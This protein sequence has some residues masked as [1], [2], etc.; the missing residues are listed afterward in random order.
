MTTALVVTCEH[1]GNN[2]PR[3]YRS[4]FT[5]PLQDAL[6]DHRGYDPGALKLA[7]TIS[8]A[9]SVPLMYTTVT[10]LLVDCNR[11]SGHRAL[12]GPEVRNLPEEELAEIRALHYEP[13]RE[14][15]SETIGDLIRRRKRVLHISVHTFTP[16]LDGTD[17]TADIALLYDPAREEEKKCASAL[18][19]EMRTAHHQL[20]IRRN[21]PYRGTSDGLTT[22]LRE[23]YTG[24]GYRGIEL[25][26]NQ[27][28]AAG[29]AADR[30]MV[31][32]IVVSSLT[33]VL[34]ANL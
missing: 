7:Q 6:T 31:S 22:A 20:R 33:K 8:S 19:R 13:Y 21:Y 24:D 17:R 27:Q 9:L 29:N 32:K 18:I 23:Q 3:E 25:E 12:H 28:L 15:V 11:S 30:A 4:L 16:N 34:A 5:G 14:G 26:V 1:G 2:V 10:R